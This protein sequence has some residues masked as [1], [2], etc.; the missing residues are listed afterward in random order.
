MCSS[1]NSPASV[2]RGRLY[3]HWWRFISRFFFYSHI[4]VNL[5]KLGFSLH[6][7]ANGGGNQRMF[8]SDLFLATL[9]VS[10][11]RFSVM[12]RLAGESVRDFAVYRPAR[13]PRRLMPAC[14]VCWFSVL[15]VSFMHVMSGWRK[16]WQRYLFGQACF[17]F[18]F[19]SP[20]RLSVDQV[21]WAPL[22]QDLRTSALAVGHG[23]QWCCIV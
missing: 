2:S 19:F 6:T 23:S 17:S 8:T 3:K 21:E 11:Q 20:I 14:F 9:N 15:T 16:L 18:F 7:T 10:K 22:I 4:M 13:L 1:H 5:F 12:K